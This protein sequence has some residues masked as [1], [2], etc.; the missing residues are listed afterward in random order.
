M[1]GVSLFLEIHEFPENT[2][3]N[4]S[5]AASAENHFYLLSCFGT[6]G[7][8]GVCDN[9]TDRHLTIAYVASK[10][11]HGKNQQASF[12]KSSTVNFRNLLATKHV[13]YQQHNPN[14]QF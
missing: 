3:C 8:S 7:L 4:T 1:S 10:M 9:Q 6:I 12:F 13:Q 14:S 11:A 2:T 5:R